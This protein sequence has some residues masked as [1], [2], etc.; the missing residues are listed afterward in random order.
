MD[1]IKNYKKIVGKVN[2]LIA[3]SI[4]SQNARRIEELR[5]AAASELEKIV[6]AVD[7]TDYL[8]IDSKGKIPKEIFLDCNFQLGT[9]YKSIVES[10][11][12]EKQKELQKNAMMRNATDNLLTENQ[13]IMLNKSL[14]A[15]KTIL[16]VVFEDERATKQIVSVYTRLSFFYQH[17]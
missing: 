10:Q 1:P 8:L 9:I 17:D 15:F 6:N 13:E 11:V 3:D 12:E 2:S 14:N 16:A 4:T 7:V 5:L